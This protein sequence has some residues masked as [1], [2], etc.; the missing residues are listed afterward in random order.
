[1]SQWKEYKLG[2]IGKI[3][4]GTTPQTKNPENYGGFMLFVTPT[5]FD[6][7][8][9]TINNSIRS[10]SEIAV[11]KLKN[12][13][14]PKDSVIVTCIGSQMGKVAINKKDCLT[15]QQINSIIPNKGFDSNFI[16]YTLK[17][18]QDYLRNLATG[19][20]TM[21]I[22]NKSSFE[23][24]T[25]S[26]PD[27]PPP[28]AIASILSSLDE[29]I[30]LNN[31]I[32]KNLEALA[33]ALFKQWFVDFNF[34]VDEHG[35]FSPLS[36]EMSEGQRG[37][38]DSGGEMIESELGMIPK[39]WRVTNLEEI[40][41][42]NIG[43]TPPRKEQQWFTENDNDVKWISIKDMGNAGTYITSTS[44]CLT[45]E[46]VKKFNIP[47]IEPNTVVVSFKLTVGR[48][49]ITTETMLS[50][51]A[52]AHVNL[53][54]EELSPEFIYLY[55]K[56]FDFDSLGSTSSIATAVNS[57][58]IKTLPFIYPNKI[59]HKSF[60]EIVKV[61][62]ESIKNNTN[63]TVRLSILRDTL[64]PKLISGEL[65]VNEVNWG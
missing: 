13:I 33:Q 53:K 37:Y 48:V 6:A 4:T 34:P 47:I 46:A 41:N 12:R 20:S 28:T 2:E 65:E 54:G 21:P 36:E 30:E 51:E 40:S 43:R 29:K 52:I 59:V 25:I 61:L 22:I 11:K 57:K 24:I 38:K 7:Y 49:S 19:G 31:A 9:K 16:Y 50:N 58:A 42:I 45:K 18:M 26:V 17:S 35:N 60:S 56:Q 5:D 32:N 63:E 14:I 44:E 23:N 64:L 27:Y 3:I 62:F 15:N 1:M 10:I 39:G 8:N 55:L